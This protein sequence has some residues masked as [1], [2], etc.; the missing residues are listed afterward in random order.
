MGR[1]MAGPVPIRPCREGEMF[2]FYSN[3]D[4]EPLGV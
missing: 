3:Y 4:V 2:E 1:R